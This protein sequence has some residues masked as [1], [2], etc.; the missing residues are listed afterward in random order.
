MTVSGRTIR[1]EPPSSGVGGDRRP[2]SP[3]PFR[4]WG[5]PINLDR[6]STDILSQLVADFLLDR[7][8]AGA[9]TGSTAIPGDGINGII[10]ALDRA[11]GPTASSSRPATR[12]W[13]RSWPARHAKF[14][15]RGRR[16]HG[17]L[18]P[19]RDPPA[20][21]ALRREAGPP[22]GAW[23]SSASRRDRARRRLPAGGRPRRRSSRTWR[24]STC[25]WR[26]SPAQIR[27]LVD[28]A[29]R[30]ALG[31]ADRHLHHRAQ[32]R[33][34]ADAV[35]PPPHAARHGPFR[36]RLSPARASSRTTRTSQRAAE[37]LNAGETGGDAR[38]RRARCGATDEVIEVAE[39]LGAGVA[40]ALLG[41][42]V[43]ARRSARTSPA[44]IGL[45]GTKPS[46]DLMTGLRH[47]ADGRLELPLLASSCPKEGQA[48][49]VQIDIDGR[50]ARASATRWRSTSSATRARR[51]GR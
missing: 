48:R 32:R 25:T 40:K 9:S 26:S 30:I 4:Q 34:G 13:R 20:Q 6:R 2:G 35:E 23:R 45:L 10:G 17:D 46:W 31:R 39:L 27:H 28:R 47:A 1:D 19:G 44:S 7:L 29:F 43:A 3:P 42:A 22:A 5:G 21:R 8:G 12:R 14:T 41:K 51:C 16:L 15:R 50:D 33:A 36:R 37:V 38:R 24:T 18:G 11:R 49:G